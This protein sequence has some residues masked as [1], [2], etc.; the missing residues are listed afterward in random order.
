MSI[1][2]NPSLLSEFHSIDSK[3]LREN[4]QSNTDVFPDNDTFFD[5]SISII[6]DE[7]IESESTYA[8]LEFDLIEEIVSIQNNE[9]DNNTFP[10]NT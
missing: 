8:E 5:L 9:M 1:K 2:E 4:I 3:T 6:D 10:P 7:G